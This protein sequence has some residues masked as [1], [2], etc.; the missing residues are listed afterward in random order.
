MSSILQ[1]KNSSISITTS[2]DIL[3]ISIDRFRDDRTWN[4]IWTFKAYGRA[5]E[6]AIDSQNFPGA[7]LGI[8]SR[9]GC[10]TI[11]ILIDQDHPHNLESLLTKVRKILHQ[12]KAATELTLA[13]GPIWRQKYERDERT[14]CEEVIGPLLMKMGFKSVRYVHGRDEYGRDFIFSEVNRFDENRHIGLQ[15]KKGSLSGTANS[16]IDDLFSQIRRALEM[17]YEEP[18]DPPIYLSEIIVAI[19][20]SFTNNAKR[21]IRRKLMSLASVGSVYFWDKATIRSL[22]RKFWIDEQ[23]STS[24]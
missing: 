16:E 17:E 8:E 13:G 10:I 6:K 23:D 11:R 19:S 12:V 15:A 20:G 3:Q 7:T 24:N 5:L 21:I 9:F 2:N 14:F 1:T 22:I 18:G 4:Q